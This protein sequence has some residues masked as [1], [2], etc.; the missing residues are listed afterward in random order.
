MDLTTLIKLATWLALPMGLF[1]AGAALA[2][3]LWLAGWAARF[4]AGLIILVSAQLL[5][6]A[7]PWTAAKL[8]RTLEIQAM[9]TAAQQDARTQY[10]AILLLGGTGTTF[11]ADDTDQFG[12]M[13]FSES[14]DRVF[15]AAKLYHQGLAPLI[16]I[17]GG[18]PDID[19]TDRPSEAQ[20][21][22]DL[23][24][25][26]GVPENSILLEDVS[27]TT[28]E[29]FLYSQAIL[30]E[31]ELQ[32]PVALVTSASHM[33]R[34]MRNART[35][36]VQA[37]AWPTDWRAPGLMNTPLP[38]LPSARALNQSQVALKELLANLIDY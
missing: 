18:N 24:I 34:A 2:F 22:R 37:H 36:E 33:P 27:R 3:L 15:H 13:D 6:F 38:W 20:G 21:I 35:M 12:T 14:V 10:D 9:R 19:G 7:M 26:L 31:K 11:S 8:H 4:R 25:A 16:L 29:N 28:R 30:K 23:L 17:S 32:G 1:A 5:F